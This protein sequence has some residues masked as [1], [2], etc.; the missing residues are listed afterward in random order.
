L[1]PELEI[2]CP[3]IGARPEAEVSLAKGNKGRNG[4]YGMGWEMVRL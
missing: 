4:H 1:L 2:L 3:E